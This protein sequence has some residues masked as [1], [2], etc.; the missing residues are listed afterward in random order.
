MKE[1]PQKHIIR[2]ILITIILIFVLFFIYI[3]YIEP[4]IIIVKEQAIYDANLPD[5]FD[6]LKIVHFSDILYGSSINEK[7]LPNII[8]KINN[9][10]PDIVLFTGDLFNDTISLKEQDLKIL[11]DNLKNIKVKIK[12][13]AV[14]GDNDVI[15]VNSYLNTLTNA[16]FLVLDNNTDLL[17]YEGNEP[18]LIVGTSSIKE[19][20]ID[21]GKLNIEDYYTIWLNHEPTI[22][23]EPVT[24]NLI[25]ASHTLKGLIKLPNDYLL[26]QEEVNNFYELNYE[27][28]TTKMYISSGLGTYKYNVRFLNNPCIYFYRIYKS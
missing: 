21:L 12:K 4:K 23:N 24:P 20:L 13:Y 9:L 8:N 3:R 22:F 28:E 26:K 18:I 7:N 2:N 25:F 11:E 19:K 1:K 17:Y 27:T 6:G 14:I 5:S 16:G 15:N 10:N